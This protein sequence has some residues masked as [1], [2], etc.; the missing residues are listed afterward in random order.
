MNSEI[1]RKKRDDFE[2]KERDAELRRQELD[3]Q[4]RQSMELRRQ[5]EVQ[6]EAERQNKYLTA[7]EMEEQRKKVRRATRR[8]SSSLRVA[9]CNQHHWLAHTSCLGTLS[10]AARGSPS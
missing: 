10:L 9:I 8:T 1:L 5:Q 3:K 4:E 6:K 7:V 2:R